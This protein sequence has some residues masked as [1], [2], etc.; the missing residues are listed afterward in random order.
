MSDLTASAW[1]AP[2]LAEAMAALAD[3]AGLRPE[4][5]T[6]PR[7]PERPE[8]GAVHTWLDA[9]AATM[10]LEVEP[11]QTTFAELGESLRGAA[12]ALL[13]LPAVEPEEPPRFLALVRGGR[14]RVVLLGADLRARRVA[15][16]R[17][18]EVMGRGHTARLSERV[19]AVIAKTRIPASR[20]DAT[21]DA[22]MAEILAPVAL[23]LGWLLRPGPGRSFGFLLRQAGAHRLL[24][25]IL[26]THGLQYVLLLSAW[27][28]IGRGALAGVIEWGWLQAWVLLLLT[29]IPLSLL[30]QW[31]Q[32]HL[33]IEVGALLKQ[34]LLHGA[35][36]SNPEV[37]RREGSGRLLGKVFES[38]AVEAMALVGGLGAVTAALELL[39]AGGVLALGAGGPLLVAALL[40]WVAVALLLI[41]RAFARAR[42]WTHDRLEMTWGLVERMVGHRTRLAQQRRAD[43]HDGEDRELDRYLLMSGRMDRVQIA[44]AAIVPRGWLALGLLALLPSLAAGASTEPV[45]VAVGGI[46]LANQA[47]SRFTAG[48]GSLAGAWIAW[49]KIRDLFV[50]GARPTEGLDP[51]VIAHFGVGE[52]DEE[53]TPVLDAR[54]LMFQYPGR[55]RPVLEGCSVQIRAGERVLL[56]GPSGGGKSTLSSLLTGLRRPSSGLLLLRGFDR[57]TLGRVGWRRGIISAP[58][59]HENHVLTAT[60][61]FNLLMGRRWPPLPQDLREAYVICEEL[62]LGPLLERMP[63]GMFQ[64]V[65]ESGWQ[66]SHGE[67]SRLFIARA[68]LQEAD[69]VVLDESFAALDPENLRLALDCVLARAK[70]LIVIAHP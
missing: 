10:G 70:T 65:G 26:V 46:F 13:R 36:Q 32:G 23:P 34:R 49:E 14:R 21:R 67:K 51:A 19:D 24:L 66:L 7:L 12:P 9:A 39:M 5:V 6:L 4:E 16:S 55:P 59:F 64:M 8:R 43:W 58:Q 47:L 20:H 1:T 27:G 15:V 29:T 38:E 45:A 60:F 56:S 62:G 2:R 17:L 25:G 53:G 28:L 33:S 11:I 52:A 3:Q 50:A 37:L 44:L 69:V 54:E 57:Q 22:L 35:L 40:L 68:L 42:D 18:A 31:L 48:L 41:H 61:A 63:A 30:G